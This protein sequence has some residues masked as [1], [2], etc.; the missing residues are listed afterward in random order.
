MEKAKNELAVKLIRTYQK[1]KQIVGT[2]HCKFYPTCSNY[3]VETYKKFNFFYATLLVVIRLLRCNWFAKR[4]YYPVKL[5]KKE[6]QDQ[7][8]LKELKHDLNNDYIDYLLSLD[9]IINSGEELYQYIYDYVNLPT[10]PVSC[11]K[12]D[13]IYSSRFIVTNEPLTEYIDKREN[14]TKY[15]QLAKI[16][17]QE[18]LIKYEPIECNLKENSNLYLSPIS[19][20]TLNDILE[21]AN[22]QDG[23][24]I[25]N[26]YEDEINYK[27]F[28][29]ITFNGKIKE[30]KKLYKDSDK[31]IIKTNNLD[32]FPYLEYIKYSV[33]YF[34]HYDKVNYFYSL[35]MKK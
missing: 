12:C 35:N 3:A 21:Y 23:I 17:Y 6:K 16:L 13:A 11:V 25:I 27:D 26:N 30:F 29:V 19:S 14:I 15:I 8:F 33:N 34:D 7:K 1:N 18:Q 9:N 22:I 32:I 4:R 28:K 20:L 10:H 24:I 5:T 31:L 2:G